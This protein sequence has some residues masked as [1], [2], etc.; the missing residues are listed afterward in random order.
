MLGF[1][2]AEES[3]RRAREVLAVPDD[4]LSVAVF[5]GEAEDAGSDLV[6]LYGRRGRSRARARRRALTRRQDRRARRRSP[7]GRAG[8]AAP[9]TR[10]G[11]RRARDA[12][13]AAR[14]R[15]RPRSGAGRPSLGRR[16]GI[17]ARER[18]RGSRITTRCAHS[19]R[20]PGDVDARPLRNLRRALRPGDA[21]S[22]RST[23]SRQAGAN[24]QADESFQAELDE[25]GRTFAGRPTPLTRAERFAPG[26]TPLPQAG[27]SRCTRGAHKLNNAL[28][29]AVLARR[30]GK[31]RIVA[32]TGA[33]QHGVA[34]ATRVRTLRSRVRR[35]HGRGGHATPAAQ[36]RAHEPARRR[37]SARSTSAPA[38][39]QGGDERGDSRLDHERRDD[40][41]PDRLVRRPRAVSGDR[42]RAAGRDRPRGARA[43]PRGREAG[44]RRSSSPASAAARTRS[45]SS[46][47]SSTTRTCGLSASRPP[48]RASLGAGNAG[49]AA[50]RALIGSG[51]RGRPDRRRALDLGRARLSRRR[52][53]ARVAAR[54]RPR[55]VRCARPTTRR[56]T[57]SATSRA[58]RGSFPA[59]EPAHA[60]ARA[61]DLDEELVLVCLSGRGDKGSRRGARPMSRSDQATGPDARPIGSRM[62]SRVD[63]LLVRPR[64]SRTSTTIAPAFR[65]PAVGGEASLPPVD[66]DTLRG[67]VARAASRHARARDSWPRTSSRTSAA[68]NCSAARRCIIS[69][70]LRDVVEIGYWLFV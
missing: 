59:L 46:P 42:A 36:R 48:R 11:Y 54:L 51:G 37:G 12:R 62:S 20:R 32:E 18:S 4:R 61:R 56:S 69:I 39:A 7:V 65:D 5:V 23:S 8:P 10:G 40:A 66:A 16:R 28:G 29:Q 24:A 19:S 41:L 47:A 30:L 52:P 6:Q 38:H 49:R 27:G 3:P 43:V 67:H 34:T 44:C 64:S 68:A 63:E 57:P 35:L 53:R 1:I 50:R 22:R 60:L 25:L 14:A 58:S 9:P 55:G 33:G 31:R 21:D 15:Q 17:E 13:R 2:L 45:A 26:Q 70:R